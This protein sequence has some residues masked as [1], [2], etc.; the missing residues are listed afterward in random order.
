MLSLY[1]CCLLQNLSRVGSQSDLLI[2]HRHKNSRLRGPVSSS[3]I[4]G[5]LG[6]VGISNWCA[7]FFEIHPNRSWYCYM[8]G[9]RIRTG[10]QHGGSEF[11][12]KS[13]PWGQWLSIK[14]G[15]IL[16]ILMCGSLPKVG[17]PHL[18]ILPMTLLPLSYWHLHLGFQ[19]IPI[20]LFPQKL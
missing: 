11:P 13:V 20:A 19:S 14:S 9:D 12:A 4:L 17:C 3:R 2:Q 18:F 1:P 10:M 6:H 7:Y 5:D 8:K 15:Y 16:Q